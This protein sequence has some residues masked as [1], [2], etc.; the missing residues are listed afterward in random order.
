M[1]SEFAIRSLT[2]IGRQ[3]VSICELSYR[4]DILECCLNIDNLLAK[5]KDLLRRR[6]PINGP[7]C[8]MI[9][10]CLSSHIYQLQ[11][12]LQEA[13]IYQVSDDFMDITS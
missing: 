13:I 3:L 10:R 8:V 2:K 11:R 4:R 7:E 1:A 5:Y 9:S 12:R 6:L